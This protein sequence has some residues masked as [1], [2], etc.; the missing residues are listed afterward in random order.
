MKKELKVIQ[1][2]CC[3]PLPISPENQAQVKVAADLLAALADPTRLSI[4]NMLLLNQGD[5][6]VCDITASFT[7]GQPTISHHLRIL[8]EAGLITGDKRGK[9]VY[10]APVL[11]RIEE[12]KGLLNNLLA[13]PVSVL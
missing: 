2:E 1:E 7:L 5:V 6:C 10:Y 11:A 3:T 9:W 8:R 13:V 4:L 12:L